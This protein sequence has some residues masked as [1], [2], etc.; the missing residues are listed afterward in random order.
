MNESL[1]GVGFAF[2][3]RHSLAASRVPGGHGGLASRATGARARRSRRAAAPR[4]KSNAVGEIC[5][6]INAGIASREPHAVRAPPNAAAVWTFRREAWQRPSDRPQ[7]DR[8]TT[9]GL[10]AAACAAT[11][12]PG[13]AC[14]P[15]G[16]WGVGRSPRRRAPGRRAPARSRALAEAAPPPPGSGPASHG[17]LLLARRTLVLAW[18]TATATTAVASTAARARRRRRR[19]SVKECAWRRRCSTQRCSDTSL[20]DDRAIIVAKTAEGAV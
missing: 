14:D 5:F 4:A 13:C 1:L 12:P 8:F 17:N 7:V 16:A 3:W 2:G 18:E 20:H 11:N 15:A 19:R 10:D 9:R 6:V